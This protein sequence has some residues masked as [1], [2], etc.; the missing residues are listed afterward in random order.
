MV[1]PWPTSS[2]LLSDRLAP[3]FD[4]GRRRVPTSTRWCGR[5]TAPTPRPTG[6]CRWPRGSGATRVSVAEAVLAAA[7]LDGVATAEIAGPG[8]INLTRRRRRSSR[9]RSPTSPPTSGWASPRDRPGA[10]RRLLGAERRQG[11]AHRAP[12]HHGDRRRARATARLPRPRRRPREPHRRLG[13]AVRDAHRAPRR[14]RRRRAEPTSAGRST[15]S[16][17]R[18]PRSSP[19]TPTSPNG[20][21]RASCAAAPRPRDDRAVATPRRDERGALERRLRQARRAAHRRRPRR[22]EPLRGPAAGVVE[23]LAAAGL[24]QSRTA[25]TSCS[26]PGSP[27]ARASRCR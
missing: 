21:A 14:A 19:T 12:P 24:L 4:A 3:A 10:R 27:T 25:P 11:D 23:R 9:R 13:P 22:G 1:G 20:P 18:R 8:F 17:R 5:P 16:T 15:R 7:D 2:T 6:R 26:R